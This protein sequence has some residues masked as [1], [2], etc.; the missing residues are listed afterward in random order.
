MLDHEVHLLVFRF[1][2]EE[3][4]WNDTEIESRFLASGIDSSACL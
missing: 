2:F 4:G 3:S 1:I